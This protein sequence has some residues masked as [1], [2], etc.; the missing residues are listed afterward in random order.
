MI[1]LV[2]PS[3]PF[4]FGFNIYKQTYMPTPGGEGWSKK[5]TYFRICWFGLGY[6]I[7]M[8]LCPYL[9]FEIL[10]WYSWLKPENV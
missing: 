9:D 2:G 4:F 7:V 3:K 8:T 1:H 6:T 5:T 10:P